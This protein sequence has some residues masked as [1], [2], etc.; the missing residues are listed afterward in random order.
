VATIKTLNFIKEATMNLK[1]LVRYLTLS[2]LVS[3]VLICSPYLA[4]AYTYTF[5]AFID[6]ESDLIIQDN[7]VQWHN[8]QWDAPGRTTDDFGTEH[9]DPT[10]ITTFDMG[11]FNWYPSW[12]E[13]TYGDVFSNIFIGLNHPLPAGPQTID[14]MVTEQRPPDD[15]EGQGIVSIHQYPLSSN[16]YTLIVKFDDAEPPGAAWYTVQLEVNP[17]PLPG[18]ILLLGS[19]LLGL[20]ALRGRRRRF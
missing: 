12:D 9:N 7:T 14:L 3:L 6:G 10:T 20:L 4:S 8:L 1:R 5:R 11:S 13:G 18:S 15:P 2:I 19:G 17:V 16:N